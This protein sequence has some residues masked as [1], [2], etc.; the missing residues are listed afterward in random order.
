[1]PK[2]TVVKPKELGQTTKAQV[3]LVPSGL[4]S[5]TYEVGEGSGVLKCGPCEGS[6]DF[7]GLGSDLNQH[8]KSTVQPDSSNRVINQP[9]KVR[10]AQAD[11]SLPCELAVRPE[12]SLRP[13]LRYGATMNGITW[14]LRVA[15]ESRL[16]I[17]ECFIS[18]WPPVSDFYTG[19]VSQI[20][21]LQGFGLGFSQEMVGSRGYESKRLV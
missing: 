6:E 3:L 1:M 17:P 5:S 11:L 13:D 14:F 16:A 9:D 4:G 7:M 8:P 12:K 21:H 20:C 2:A 18:R 15:D 10:P 19:F